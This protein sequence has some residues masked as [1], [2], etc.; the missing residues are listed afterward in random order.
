[1]PVCVHARMCVCV[2]VYV[3]VHVCCLLQT[4]NGGIILTQ[5]FGAG[6]F[7]SL[8]EAIELDQAARGNLTDI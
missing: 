2:Y 7:K 5:G 8:F 1:M 6:N 4:Y 3:C